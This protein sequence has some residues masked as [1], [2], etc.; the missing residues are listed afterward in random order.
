LETIKIS[1]TVRGKSIDTVLNYHWIKNIE[2]KEEEKQ[3]DTKIIASECSFI[4]G[5]RYRHN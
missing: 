4:T 2:N 5:D 1:K 3:E